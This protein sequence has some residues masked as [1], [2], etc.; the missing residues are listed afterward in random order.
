MNKD[1]LSLLNEFEAGILALLSES[2]GQ[3]IK[4]GN[5]PA[6]DDAKITSD[7]TEQIR[8]HIDN[9]KYLQNQI[10][11]LREDEQYAAQMLGLLPSPAFLID[12]SSERILQ[13]NKRVSGT[14]YESCRSLLD[15]FTDMEQLQIIRKSI[16]Q[17]G[18]EELIIVPPTDD[19]KQDNGNCILL[20][21]CDS[22]AH[23]GSYA[24]MILLT[25][26]DLE[27]DEE[28]IE[29]LQD[30]FDLTH[31][32]ASIAV[33]ITSGMQ[34]VEI[35][36][37]RN[38]SLQTVRSQIK[39]IKSKTKVRDMPEL[40][41]HISILSADLMITKP[42]NDAEPPAVITLPSMLVKKLR[43]SDGRNMDYII[44][45]DPDGTPLLSFHSFP[46]GVR[47]PNEAV[48][49][50]RANN[51]AII[52]PYRAGYADSDPLNEL[53]GEALID[54]CVEDARELLDHLSVPAASI[55]GNDG[56]SSYA[57][58]FAKAYSDRTTNITLSGKP[59]IWKAEWYRILYKPD[60]VASMLSRY[61]PE[62]AELFAWSIVSY[63]NKHDPKEFCRF[64]TNGSKVDLANL[65]ANFDLIKL[66][67]TDVKYGMKNGVEALFKDWSLIKLDLTHEVK[68][69]PHNIT[70]LYGANDRVVPKKMI[71][72]FVSETGNTKLELIENAGHL[73][74]Y[75]HWKSILK[76]ASRK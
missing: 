11:L 45:G 21:H 4:I 15:L 5:L 75:S 68:S 6:A 36:D 50:T 41:R 29:V 59:P 14:A 35:A 39:R 25:I 63:M 54:Q 1:L 43:L 76:T 7:L 34:P 24:P 44:Q 61:L 71:D 73:L 27:F 49:Y 9:T 47:W 62:V 12:A 56:G 69:L 52:T 3:E 28:V 46:Y 58:R 20:K 23:T 74:F 65:E 70:L 42:Q 66:M 40:V 19:Q 55:L 60:R 13:I 17:L 53:K 22:G 31:A 67:A 8:T 64:C 26:A 57:I 37:Q 16:S 38:V 48:T 33:Q 18:H 2:S 30:A 10:G 72:S 51:I 32:E